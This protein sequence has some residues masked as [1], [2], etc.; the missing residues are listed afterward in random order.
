MSFENERER[1]LELLADRAIFGLSDAERKELDALGEKFPEL[2]SDDS[3]EVAASAFSLSTVGDE[4]QIPAALRAK[5]DADALDFWGPTAASDVAAEDREAP[6]ITV[7]Y[8]KP[9]FSLTQWLGWGVAAIACAALVFNIWVSRVTSPE[10]IARDRSPVSDTPKEPTAGERLGQFLASAKD[11]VKS[12]WSS[13]SEDGSVSGEVVW[14]DSEQ[15]GFMTFKGLQVNDTSKETYQ[16]WIFD[17]TQDD[18]T[19]I[20]GGV[21]DVDKNGEVVIPIDAK[22][23]VRNP[24]MFAVTVEKPGG[25]VVSKREK[26][27]AIAKV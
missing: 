25:V 2:A 16:L 12:S 4:V 27:V 14:S 26:I 3:F 23:K 24:K 18:K 7:K 1:M 22:L 21:F 9:G 11:A 6:V 10:N 20:D 15:K 8:D 19:P 17:E 5:L 13:P